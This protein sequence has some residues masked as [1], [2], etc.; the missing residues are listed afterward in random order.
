[1]RLVITNAGIAAALLQQSG[2]PKIDL[3]NFKVGAGVAYTPQVTDTALHGTIL[4]AGAISNYTVESADTCSYRLIIDETVGDFSFGEVGLYDAGGTLFALGSLNSVQIKQ[5]VSGTDI[6]NIIDIN[7]KL[8]MTQ[9]AA[10]LDFTILLLQNAKLLE[11]GSLELLQPPVIAPSNAYICHSNDDGNNTPLAIRD[12]DY[13]WKFSTH[14]YCVISSGVIVA[15]PNNTATRCQSAS[16]SNL[17][18][19]AGKY[20]IQFKTGALKGLPRLVTLFAVDA[21]YG[22][23]IQWSSPLGSAPNSGEIF[24]LYQ[25]NFSLLQTISDLP[26]DLFALI[27][28]FSPSNSN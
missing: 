21:T 10:V 11:I 18:V 12:N 25:S 2:G 17:D 24:D 5:A 15:G 28:A 6:G 19:Q 9:L 7:V 4:Y 13:S 20:I 23:Y 22:P 1:M 14:Q 3:I 8:Q 26:D 16:L 27:A